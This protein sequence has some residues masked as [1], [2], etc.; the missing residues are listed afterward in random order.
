MTLGRLGNYGTI[1]DIDSPQNDKETVFSLWYDVTRQTLLK[2]VMPN[3]AITRKRESL[4]GTN[5]DDDFGYEFYYAYP[6][7]CLRLLGVGNIKDKKNDYT[8]ENG[9]IYTGEE[10]ESGLPIRYVKDVKDVS[11]WDSAFKELMSYGLAKNVCLSITQDTNKLQMMDALYQKA[12]IGITSFNAQENRPIRI[13]YSK[14]KASRYGGSYA[15][16]KL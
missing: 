12:M 5:T 11:L 2:E 7:D 15:P 9:R 14:F 4:L 6:N 10:Y 8:V 13:S 3:F 1:S 16:E